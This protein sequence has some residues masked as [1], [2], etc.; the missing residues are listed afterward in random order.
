MSLSEG[1]PPRRVSEEECHD[2]TKLLYIY[3]DR[4]HIYIYM[5]VTF[6]Y[7]PFFGGEGRSKGASRSEV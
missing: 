3:I 5:C 4:V 7:I 6:F 1:A 2:L